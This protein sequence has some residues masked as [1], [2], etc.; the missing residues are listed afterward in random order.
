MFQF[1][2]YHTQTKARSKWQPG[3]PLP[4]SS[5]LQVE[6]SGMQ[7]LEIS[8]AW[9]RTEKT[10]PFYVLGDENGVPRAWDRTGSVQVGL[11]AMGATS[12]TVLGTVQLTL[13]IS[14]GT[15][16]SPTLVIYEEQFREPLVTMF[17][18]H[19]YWVFAWGVDR[20]TMYDDS[21][22]ARRF[23]KTSDGLQMTCFKSDGDYSGLGLNPRAELRLEGVRLQNGISYKL[24]IELQV[25]RAPAGFEFFQIMRDS[26]PTLQLEVR[27]GQLGVRYFDFAKGHLYPIPLQPLAPRT[28]MRWEIRAFL[29][30]DGGRFEVFLDGVSV[31]SRVGN[32]V[33]GSNT[34]NWIQYGVYCNQRPE[35]DQSILVHEVT[36]RT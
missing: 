17:R 10:A 35:V 3:T 5:A 8:G 23:V 18:K 34:R 2:L 9:T 33:G 13:S 36:I 15:N 1:T 28:R 16:S 4:Q 30:P 7:S 14:S 11:K 31:W 12:S 6:Y 25:L 24:G 27:N 26:K 29:A 22:V 19:T 20:P 21:D 32:N